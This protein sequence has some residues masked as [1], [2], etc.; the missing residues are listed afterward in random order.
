[1]TLHTILQGLASNRHKRV[2][3]CSSHAENLFAFNCS[4][5]HNASAVCTSHAN[6]STINSM[7]PHQGPICS[8][9]SAVC[10]RGGYTYSFSVMTCVVSQI[11]MHAYFSDFGWQQARTRSS[12]YGVFIFDRRLQKGWVG[13]QKLS[14]GSCKIVSLWESQRRRYVMYSCLMLIADC[15]C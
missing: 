11:C 1:M 14:N 7:P 15:R 8:R 9:S 6:Q 10:N 5:R 13:W 4:H 2:R 12:T 3:G